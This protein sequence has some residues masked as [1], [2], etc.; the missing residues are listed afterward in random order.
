MGGKWLSSAGKPCLAIAACTLP[1]SLGGFLA[2]AATNRMGHSM[3]CHHAQ[4]DAGC[5]GKEKGS[6]HGEVGAEHTQPCL[7]LPTPTHAGAM[8][9]HP[10]TCIL[11]CQCFCSNQINYPLLSHEFIFTSQEPSCACL[12]GLFLCLPLMCLLLSA[13]WYCQEARTAASWRMLRL[14]VAQGQLT[15]LWWEGSKTP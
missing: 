12:P 10:V 1:E 11:A 2:A 15:Q 7:P 14:S 5:P 6:W 13:K 3:V 8:L 4:A 9:E